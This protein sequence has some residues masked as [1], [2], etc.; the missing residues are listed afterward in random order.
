AA[1]IAAAGNM[2]DEER[3]AMIA[4][5]VERLADKLN[6]N[7]DDIDGWKRLIRAYAVMGRS[8]DAVAAGR[9][10]AEHFAGD[11]D[12]LNQIKE[13]ASSMGLGL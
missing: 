9:K 1:D 12:K 6:D 4:G 8:E 7:P 5:M 3:Q 13:F 11:A 10:A 2:S